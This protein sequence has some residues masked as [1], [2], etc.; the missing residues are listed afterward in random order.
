MRIEQ[1]H[2]SR[3]LRC[4]L[5]LAPELGASAAKQHAAPSAVLSRLREATQ[6]MSVC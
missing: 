6:S 2:V 3:E 5:L 4:V 1:E